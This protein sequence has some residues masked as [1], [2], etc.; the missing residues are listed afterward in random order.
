MKWL[1]A[2]REKKWAER[3]E[4]HKRAYAEANEE[5]L[6]AREWYAKRN[7]PVVKGPCQLE[8]CVFWRQVMGGP[9]DMSPDGGRIFVVAIA[10]CDLKG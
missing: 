9:I 1:D 4:A 7:C 2:R 8:Q 5:I 10:K 3:T 6:Q